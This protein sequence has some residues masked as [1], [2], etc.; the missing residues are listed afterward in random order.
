MCTLKTSNGLFVNF[1]SF[2]TSYDVEQ[3]YGIITSETD[4]LFLPEW[5]KLPNYDLNNTP[6]NLYG[7][8]YF[9]LEQK[10]SA[11]SLILTGVQ[12]V[13]KTMLITEFFQNINRVLLHIN[14]PGF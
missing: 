2:C 5:V 14:L 11:K 7:Q 3:D 13:G 8:S 10:L 4:I 1:K 6:K 9:E 12:G